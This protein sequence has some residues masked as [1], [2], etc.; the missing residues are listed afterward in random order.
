MFDVK[1]YLNKGIL[2]ES[3]DERLFRSVRVS[4][5][6]IG[7]SNQV[8][9]DPEDLYEYSVRISSLMYQNSRILLD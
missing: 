9:I 5:D 7:W 8:D 3:R 4:F 1:P 6:S 2:K